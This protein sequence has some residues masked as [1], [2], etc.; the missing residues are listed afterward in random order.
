MVEPQ[1]PPRSAFPHLSLCTSHP[2][3]LQFST[4]PPM[5]CIN[6]PHPQCLCPRM[7]TGTLEDESDVSVNREM[8]D[9]DKEGARLVTIQQPQA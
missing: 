3:I 5:S 1:A 6:T 4:L 7:G 8:E 9:G 2:R